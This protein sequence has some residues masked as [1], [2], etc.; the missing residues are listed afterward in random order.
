ML[1][2]KSFFFRVTLFLLFFCFSRLLSAQQLPSFSIQQ[3]NGRIMKPANLSKTKPLIL[4]YFSPD[5]DHCTVLLNSMFRQIDKFRKGIILL[6]T[7]R[8][9][10]ELEVFEKKY[11]I[12]KY[13]N[14]I[15]GT[16]TKP[17]FLQKLYQLQTTPFTA[18]FNKKGNL[19]YSYKKETPVNDLI[20]R[21]N[22]I[23]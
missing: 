4:V 8:P 13:A 22:A 15:S 9:V 14:V 5:C 18:L 6:V 1:M 17:L 19:L 10:E 2:L 11:K 20:R 7:F 16:E 12:D 23:R 3:T 21:L